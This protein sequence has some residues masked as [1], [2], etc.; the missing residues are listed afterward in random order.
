[1]K[2]KSGMSVAMRLG[3]AFSSLIALLIVIVSMALG[4]FNALNG[5]VRD[6]TQVSNVES[7]M[8]SNL[9][10]ATQE[11]RIAYRTVIIVN[12][13][14]QISDAMAKY[15]DAKNNYYAKEKQLA[16]MLQSLPSS[17]QQEKELMLRLQSQRPGAFALVDRSCNLGSINRNDEARTVML[18]LA[19]PAMAKMVETIR[20]LGAL[21]DQR[22]IDA[23]QQA[24]QVHASVRNWTIGLSAVS[25]LLA[26]LISLA[27]TR[28]L[29]NTIG[30]EPQLVARVM[31]EV[32]SGNLTALPSLRPGDTHSLAAAIAQ[33]IEK[34]RII[35]GEVKGGADNLSSAAQQLSATSQSLSQGASE[36]ASG[37]EETSSSLE[38][39]SSSICRTNDNAKITENIA[40][41]A[42]E[43]ATEGGEAVRQ[44]VLAMRKI[45]NK[46]SI[47]DDIAYQTN[48]LAL[49]ATIEAAR[50][51]EHGRGFAVVAAEVRKLAERSQ[52]AAK[53]ISEVADSSVSLAEHA[54]KLLEDIVRSSSRNADLV[55]EIAAASNEQAAGVQQINM[56]VQHLNANTQQNASASEQLASTAEEMSS[57]AE[58]LQ[59]LMHFFHLDDRSLPLRAQ[60]WNQHASS[61]G[62]HPPPFSADGAGPDAS[63]FVRF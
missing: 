51:G 2:N 18:T 55:Q 50:A 39:I 15:N 52:V 44:T 5:A 3:L 41:H 14:A 49:N 6:I 20:E 27:I 19:T 35:I 59:E 58:N 56:A 26:V 36:S 23:A 31:H 54:G 22:S 48:L 43:V 25:M 60:Q 1:M 11:M 30:G 62:S 16:D 8:A 34:L 4:G 12:D 57:Q 28:N 13:P 29:L 33:T 42:S 32:A 37:I 38:E 9:M 17:S 46:I 45:A 40:E 24:E 10:S 63:D 21:E 61:G 47:I 53:D 7:K